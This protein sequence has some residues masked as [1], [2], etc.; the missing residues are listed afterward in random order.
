MESKR[1]SRIAFRILHKFRSGHEYCRATS[2]TNVSVSNKVTTDNDLSPNKLPTPENATGRTRCGRQRVS[3]PQPVCKPENVVRT[4]IALMRRTRFEF[5]IWWAFVFAKRCSQTNTP[6]SGGGLEVMLLQLFMAKKNMARHLPVK[7]RGDAEAAGAGAR[8]GRTE[9][10]ETCSG[11]NC[12][13]AC[14]GW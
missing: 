10:V 1:G 5:V 2:I 9:G 7:S 14:D 13:L 6:L 12:D 4:P 3:V 11:R 8:E